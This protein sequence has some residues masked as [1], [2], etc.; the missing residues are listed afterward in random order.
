VRIAAPGGDCEF[1]F[2]AREAALWRQR[3]A[4]GPAS[5]QRFAATVLH[6]AGRPSGVRSS[7]AGRKRVTA[8]ISRVASETLDAAGWRVKSERES[9]Q[10]L[11][12]WEKPTK[13]RLSSKAGC[14]TVVIVG[15]GLWKEWMDCPPLPL[16][17]LEMA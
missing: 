8:W 7:L 5:F 12:R 10:R 13:G 9:S 15:S 17:G 1:A 14:E 2:R 4:A 16:A 11:R 3:P 6:A